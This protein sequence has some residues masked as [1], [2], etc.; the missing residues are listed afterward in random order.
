[1]AAAAGAPAATRDALAD[2]VHDAVPGQ[3][4]LLDRRSSW[5]AATE[6]FDAEGRLVDEGAAKFLGML[7]KKLRAVVE[8]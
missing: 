3:P 2:P 8:A 4:G 5:S 1:M 7:M 6:A